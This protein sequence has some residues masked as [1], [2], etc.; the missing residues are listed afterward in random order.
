M[1]KI[2]MSVANTIVGGHCK[3]TCSDSFEWLTVGGNDV[4]NLVTTCVDKHGVATQTYQQ[5]DDS[6]CKPAG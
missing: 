1:K 6:N 2:T 4:C 5:A 3:T